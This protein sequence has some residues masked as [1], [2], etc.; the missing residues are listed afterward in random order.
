MR[1]LPTGKLVVACAAGLLLP[2]VTTSPALAQPANDEI[3]GATPLTLNTTVTEDTT[4]AT[5]APTDPS[6]CGAPNNSV[7]FSFTATESQPIDVDPTG[8]DYSVSTYVLTDFGSG[9]VVI[10]CNPYYFA[11]GLRFEASAGTTYYIMIAGAFGG[12][13]LSLT[14]RSGIVMTVLIN[15][16]GTVDSQGIAVVGGTLSCTQGIPAPSEVTSPTLAVDLRQKISKT[17]V[18]DGRRNLFI[19]CPTTPTNWSATIIGANGPFQKGQAEV[20]ITGSACDNFGCDNPELRQIVT[21]RKK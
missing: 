17:L 14:L 18:I 12:G 6:G 11:N 13:Q 1:P 16:T 5:S 7:W 19:P 15:Q 10:A 21:L 4:L 9:P 8:S 2:L 20:L 3:G